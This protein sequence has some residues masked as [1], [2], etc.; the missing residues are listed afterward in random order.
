[1]VKVK[2]NGKA[3]VLYGSLHE[4]HEVDVLGIFS[5]S[6]RSLENEGRV[7]LHRGL[8][9]ALHDFHV[10]DVEGADG[11]TAGIG[12]LEHLGCCDKWHGLCSFQNVVSSILFAVR[13]DFKHN[14]PCSKRFDISDIVGDNNGC[15]SRKCLFQIIDGEGAG[16]VVEPLEGLVDEKGLPI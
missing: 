16:L 10:V 8:S 6:G 2:R 1:M 12:R 14:Q 5:C 13:V 3:G 7:L 15:P 4:L 9:D 11:I